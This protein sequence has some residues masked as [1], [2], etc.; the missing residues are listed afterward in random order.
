M[1]F[2]LILF[3]IF[4]LV[5]GLAF[6]SEFNAVSPFVENL[7]QVDNSIL[8][9]S[10][11]SWGNVVVQR[12]GIVFEIK[13]G[14]EHFKNLYLK[15]KNYEKIEIIGENPSE[16]YFNFIKGLEAD[17]WIKDVKVYENLR[18]TGISKNEDFLISSSQSGKPFL[19]KTTS[20][21]IFILTLTYQHN[22][23]TDT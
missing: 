17:K 15:F 8:F 23:M 9:Y 12:N 22:L 21:T 18:V 19:S 14:E 2:K 20:K 13:D 7:G 5:A 6:G 11:N 16:T 1:R 10:Q 4:S 3:L